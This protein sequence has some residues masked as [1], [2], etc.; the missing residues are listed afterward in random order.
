MRARTK[1]RILI[2]IMIS[3]LVSFVL[4][5]A[6]AFVAEAA[7][8]VRLGDT[9]PAVEQVQEQLA[10]YGYSVPVDGKFGP[11]TLRAVRHFQRANGLLVDGIV[12]PRTQRALGRETAVTST[13]PP[14]RVQPSSAECWADL[15]AQNGLP[16]SFTNIIY[17]ESR[18]QPNVTSSTGCCHGL[19]QIHRIHLPKPECEAY[20]VSDLFD[21]TKNLCVAGVLYKRSGMS[22][23]SL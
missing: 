5:I 21:P 7:D 8:T 12:G 16:A 22:P 11:R 2:T 23:W 6:S 4:L 9:G 15:V 18:C 20:S 13:A 1:D 17:R 19:A 14:A 3:G 10:D